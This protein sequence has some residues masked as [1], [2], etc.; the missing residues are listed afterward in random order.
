MAQ[1]L[2]KIEE[3]SKT[4]YIDN[5]GE[6]IV[7]PKYLYG[8]D[9]YKGYAI[10]KNYNSLYGI[11]DGKGKNKIAFGNIFSATLYGNRYA[12]IGSFVQM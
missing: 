9:F 12:V 3:N 5:S 1:Y 2:F 8:T 10:V 7:K 4:G 6:V 11:I